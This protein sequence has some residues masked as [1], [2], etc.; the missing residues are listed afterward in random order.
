[1]THTPH[2]LAEEFPNDIEIIHELKMNN[3]HFQKLFDEYH[4][5]NKEIHRIEIEVEAASD[6]TTENLKKQ[7]LLLKDQI[8]HMI[9]EA[10]S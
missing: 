3:T 5:V 10:N 9:H 1:M 7:R 6:V 8:N 4:E 2:E